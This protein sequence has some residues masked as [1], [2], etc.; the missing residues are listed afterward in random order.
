MSAAGEVTPVADG[1]VEVLLWKPT[2]EEFFNF[3]FNPAFFSAFS[4]AFSSLAFRLSS[5]FFFFA[6]S[7]SACFF[8]AASRAS[9]ARCRAAFAAAAFSAAFASFAAT[10]ASL[11][12]S[13]FDFLVFSGEGAGAATA[14][15]GI[16]T[17]ATGGGAGGVEVAAAAA[18]ASGVGDES[19][20]A[21][22]CCNGAGLG[23]S[24]AAVFWL[25]GDG[26]TGVELTGKEGGICESMT[27]DLG[28]AGGEAPSGR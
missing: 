19:G 2:T 26:L 5:S 13:F 23:K 4:C 10:W 8:A 12:R 1:V 22:A 9:F 16:V 18:I 3:V 20:Y 28:P 24:P 6:A 14:P 25:R 7:L 15:V 21:L 27:A 11:A 17:G